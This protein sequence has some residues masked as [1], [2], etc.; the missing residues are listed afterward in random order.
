MYSS[1]VTAKNFINSLKSEIDTALPF[2]DNVYLDIIN[3]T[4]QLLYSS[5]IKELVVKNCE[6]EIVT[7]LDDVEIEL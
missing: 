5:I 6:I 1:G 4:E 2:D 7:S 3:E